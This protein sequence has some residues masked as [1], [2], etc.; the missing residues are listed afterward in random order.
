M[1]RNIDR[2]DII[3]DIKIESKEQLKNEIINFMNEL[4]SKNF[5]IF[6]S[7]ILKYYRPS[8]YKDI[9][10]YT[11]LLND[12]VD[13]RSRVHFILHDLNEI[14]CCKTCGKK[15]NVKH[16]RILDDTPQYCS[17]Y[18]SNHSK[19]KAQKTSQWYK[20]MTE[21]ERLALH[22]TLCEAQRKFH[23]NPEN[24]ER[25]LSKT[26][27]TKKERYGDEKYIN[28]DKMKQTKLKKHGDPFFS[29]REKAKQTNNSK[30]SEQRQKEIDKRLAT[31]NKHK[32]E[33]PEFIKRIQEKSIN[34]RKK[35]NGED[36][37]GRR[38]CQR[39]L[40]EHYGVE[41][42][43]QI[44]EVKEHR[45]QYNKEQY[46]VEWHIA[47][48][49][50]RE[51]SRQSC[52]NHYGVDNPLQ[53]QEVIDK[54]KQHNLD[55]YGVEY[56]WQREDV[57]QSIRNTNKE[58][59][60]YES[61]MQNPDIRAKASMN[62]HY[63][64]R[65][66]DSYPELCIY[67]WLVDNNIPFEY[68]P[69]IV[70]PYEYNGVQHFYMPDFKIYDILY[71]VKGDHFFKDKNINEQMICPYNRS[72]DALYEIKH[73]CMLKN[74]V[75]IMTSSIYRMFILYVEQTKGEDFY[76]KIKQQKQQNFENKCK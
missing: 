74:N 20:N 31:Y 73:Q 35:N 23:A 67:I 1:K 19:E 21:D 66:F 33:D 3:N 6:N 38:K 46:G 16:W 44:E 13:F 22:N 2:P 70:L 65:S 8:L 32:E 9:I 45:K 58:K 61:A 55:N 47:S 50:I 11:S 15:L 40:K 14:P 54:I 69:K 7:K 48:K 42:P 60:G 27:K 4:K 36:Y 53:A 68:Q 25:K 39:T 29:N 18:C 57:K 34:T 10:K 5:L 43:M 28:I 49:E 30:S 41:N 17:S 64:G 52:Q 72:L 71:E 56:N 12:D 75:V 51:K 62:I 24:K 26:R 37:T 63:D 76:E 59:Y